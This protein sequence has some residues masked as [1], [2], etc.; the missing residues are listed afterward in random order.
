MAFEGEL[1]LALMGN[2]FQRGHD[3]VGECGPVTDVVQGL[4]RR[5]GIALS[6]LGKG[7]G[8]VQQDLRIA[9]VVPGIAGFVRN[10]LIPNDV[11]Q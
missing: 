8:I 9:D 2:I 1:D 3:V 6:A 5:G 10:F 7:L 11:L 4:L